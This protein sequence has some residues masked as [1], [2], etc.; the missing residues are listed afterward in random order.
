METEELKREVGK[1]LTSLQ[2]INPDEVSKEDGS[3]D[4]K[5]LEARQ[6]V[7]QAIS[8]LKTWGVDRKYLLD[9]FFLAGMV[10]GHL[11]GEVDKSYST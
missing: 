10:I 2:D 3:M 7:R 1:V 11:L 9:N 5:K 8:Q 4:F 6:E